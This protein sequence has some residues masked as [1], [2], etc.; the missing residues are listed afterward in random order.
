MFFSTKDATLSKHVICFCHDVRSAQVDF[1]FIFIFLFACISPL[2]QVHLS[3][4]AQTEEW[5]PSL[6]HRERFY[7]VPLAKDKVHF[8]DTPEALQSCRNIVLKVKR[9]EGLH[10]SKRRF[11]DPGFSWRFCL[12]AVTG[13]WHRGSRHGVAANVW[14]FLN[15]GGCPDT[16]CSLRSGFPVRP[17]RKRILSTPRHHQ[18][19]Q[20][21]VLLEK[22]S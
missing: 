21:F 14:L 18:F 15:S 9:L 10:F 19:H 12:Y 17:L 16:A 20:E 8:V 7:Q 11:T 5:I 13:R 2:R 4:S 1:A 6:S 22:R 3:N